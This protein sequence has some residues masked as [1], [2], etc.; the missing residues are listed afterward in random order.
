ME[1]KQE[2]DR[3][4]VSLPKI[5]HF[6]ETALYGKTRNADAYLEKF[7]DLNIEALRAMTNKKLRYVLLDIDACIAPSYGPILEENLQKIRELISQGVKIGVYSN[8]KGMERLNPIREMGIPIYDGELAKPLAEG[9]EGV[10]EKFGFNP[11][12]T[13]MVGDNPVTDGGAVGVLEGMVFVK[14]I[15][16]D[17][18][19]KLRFSKKCSLFAQKMLR[20]LTLFRT[21]IGNR[22]ILKSENLA[23]WNDPLNIIPAAAE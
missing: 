1:N 11:K 10:C 3:E 6:I 9:F 13:L 5:K 7:A 2:H 21:L 15:P 23:N 4:G 12:E 8:C 19:V 17:K 14:P 16:N 18:N 20:S 22:K